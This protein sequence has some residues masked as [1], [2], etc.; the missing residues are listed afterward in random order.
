MEL[1]KCRRQKLVLSKGS[2]VEVSRG[3]GGGGGGSRGAA[4]YAAKV[5]DVEPPPPW[6]QSGKLSKVQRVL[7]E[8]EQLVSEGEPKPLV[9]SVETRCVR[10]LP[11]SRESQQCS[12]ELD[13]SVEAKWRNGWWHGFVKMVLE[14]SRYCVCID[15]RVVDDVFE[16]S[17]LREHWSWIRGRWYPT[18]KKE[19]NEQEAPSTLYNQGPLEEPCVS[20]DMPIVGTD[21]LEDSTK[22]EATVSSYSAKNTE[23]QPLPRTLKTPYAL[24]PARKIKRGIL[25]GNAASRQLLKKLS[26]GTAKGPSVAAD[27]VRELLMEAS[28]V[29][30]GTA[31]SKKGI[32]GGGRLKKTVI[33]DDPSVKSVAGM[34]NE[35]QKAVEFNDTIKFA[36]RRRGKFAISKAKYSNT[37]K[38]GK[39]DNAGSAI[40]RVV[41][42]LMQED[43]F[44]RLNCV[45]GLQAEGVA[46]TGQLPNK[47]LGKNEQKCEGKSHK[48]K[49]RKPQ[50]LVVVR[51]EVP[52]TGMEHN[53]TSAVVVGE[54]ISKD[55]ATWRVQPSSSLGVLHS[56]GPDKSRREGANGSGNFKKNN[57][58]CNAETS[59]TN[60]DQPLSTCSEGIRTPICIEGSSESVS[61]ESRC[62]FVKTSPVWKM[63]ESMEIFQTTPQNPHFIP[64]R[65]CKEGYREG[66]AIGI[67]ATF[68]SLTDKISNLLFDDLRCHF[69]SCLETLCD[70]EKHGFE[71]TALRSHVNELLAIKEKQEL[72]QDGLKDTELEIADKERKKREISEQMQE[73]DKKMTELQ[74]KYAVLKSEKE[75]KDVEIARL[76]MSLKGNNEQ[77]SSVRLK[78]EQLAA[79]LPWKF[80]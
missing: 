35:D 57:D 68:A 73:I 40:K 76:R 54:P 58:L 1:L 47:E 4:W 67:M 14:D 6:K 17:D 3:D 13:E 26:E 10:P 36:I 60:E 69:D 59:N 45:L 53:V 37:H 38:P 66:A 29:L 70:M 24:R 30:N 15:G 12:F 9:E 44:P 32:S 7:V 33:V 55:Y 11:P 41:Q 61:G 50:K 39:E 31:K 75:K 64:L 2:A 43:G 74:A 63:I 20:K 78:F 46:D 71:V 62:L 48:R 21:V 34:E 52:E 28:R 65:V 49:R 56:G 22:V 23:V 5:V 77:I 19:K 51:P 79:L 25:I 72:L 27:Q 80:N 18:G 42:T 16:S 8:Y